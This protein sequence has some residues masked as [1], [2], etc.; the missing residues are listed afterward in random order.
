MTPADKCLAADRLHASTATLRERRQPSKSRQPHPQNRRLRG[1]RSLRPGTLC[2]SELSPEAVPKSWPRFRER[3]SRPLSDAWPCAVK[4]AFVKAEG[5]TLE[6]RR[7]FG[8]AAHKEIA[9]QADDTFPS[10]GGRQCG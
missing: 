7:Q 4:R 10:F 6:C 9:L 2:G 8:Q 3:P 1:A 5:R